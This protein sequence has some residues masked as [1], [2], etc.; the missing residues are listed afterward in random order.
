MIKRLLILLLLLPLVLAACSGADSNAS[1]TEPPADQAEAPESE[2]SQ[3]ESL[4]SES[5]Q[6]EG[7]QSEATNPDP[8]ATSAPKVEISYDGPQMECTLVS[9]EPEAP[10]ELV[11]ILSVKENDWVSGPET[12]AVTIVEY[13]D[14]Q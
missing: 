9:S 10:S 6:N 14:F 12:A 1:I 13:S 4:Q 2:G 11:A 8:T 5:P 7:A 3:S